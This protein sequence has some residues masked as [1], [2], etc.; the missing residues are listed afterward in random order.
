MIS[1][2]L[3]QCWPILL[4]DL[5]YWCIY[6]TLGGRWVKATFHIYAYKWSDCGAEMSKFRHSQF[7]SR[8][9]KL[10]YGPIPCGA[11]FAAILSFAP[12]PS[13]FL[14]WR[15]DV[16]TSNDLCWSQFSIQLTTSLP[17][18]APCMCQHDLTRRPLV[19]HIC[20]SES[21]Q[22]WFR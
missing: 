12:T 16:N 22:H 18:S 2:Y 20:L 14:G 8:H 1:H 17:I 19:P 4:I 15:H 3:N 7:W 6:V 9:E 11:G 21:V 13:L 5:V 10:G